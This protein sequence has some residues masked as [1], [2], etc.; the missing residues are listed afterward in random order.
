MDAFSELR[1]EL[2]SNEDDL[3]RFCLICSLPSNEL[4]RICDGGFVDHRDRVHAP[5]NYLLYLHS[6]YSNPYYELSG[7]Q[8]YVRRQLEKGQFG[9]IP[10]RMCFDY[11]EE[12]QDADTCEAVQAL[13]S[14][15]S[16]LETTI[17]ERFEAIEKS[18]NAFENTITERF[19]S[20]EQLI[21]DKL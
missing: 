3:N 9:F 4:E 14:Q 21:K 13:A 7:M 10:V 19:E 2:N 12:D 15:V 6:I 20:L 5:W 17:T 8:S 18:R 1:D 16:G 11:S